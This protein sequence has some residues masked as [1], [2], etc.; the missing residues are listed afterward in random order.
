MI[1]PSI[2]LKIKGKD[3]FQRLLKMIKPQTTMEPSGRFDV[4]TN[5]LTYYRY[6]PT[7]FWMIL[8][9]TTTAKFE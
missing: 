1:R 3:Q 2:S 5:C 6:Y 7:V 4:A 9:R 8:L